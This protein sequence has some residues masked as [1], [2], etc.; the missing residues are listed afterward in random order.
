VKTQCESTSSQD[1][2]LGQSVAD[3]D[4]PSISSYLKCM[5][6]VVQVPEEDCALPINEIT[7]REG[8]TYL[9]VMQAKIRN[10]FSFTGINIG[11]NQDD[12]EA[13]GESSE[14]V[15]DASRDF[16]QIS[17]K[18]LAYDGDDEVDGLGA[19]PFCSSE[20]MGVTEVD[21]SKQNSL[22]DDQMQ[23]LNDLMR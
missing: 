23:Y 6:N 10:S 18:T 2:G 17:E 5:P 11:L 21:E 22:T 12:E 14:L 4:A 20:S 13:P 19:M 16:D 9:E 3:L 8:E 7:W 1:E 15:A